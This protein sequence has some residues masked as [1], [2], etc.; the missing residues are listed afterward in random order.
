MPQTSG[1]RIERSPCPSSLLDNF[2]WRR[3]WPEERQSVALQFELSS[4]PARF[5]HSHVPAAFVHPL[6]EVLNYG[7]SFFSCCGRRRRFDVHNISYVHQRKGEM[8]VER[9]TTRR[10]LV[11]AGY[12]EVAHNLSRGAYRATGAR[13]RTSSKIFSKNV[14]GADLFVSVASAVGKTANRLPSG[15]RSTL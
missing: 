7:F 8:N 3:L 2:F 11:L 15:A 5:R 4:E 14:T 9:P 10:P 13:R 12:S 6:C 1:Y